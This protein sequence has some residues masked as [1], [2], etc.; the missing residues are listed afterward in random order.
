MFRLFLFHHTFDSLLHADPRI[1]CSP[2]TMH[3][4][5][6]LYVVLSRKQARNKKV[7]QMWILHLTSNYSDIRYVHARACV[8]HAW[9]C[10]VS[11]RICVPIPHSHTAHRYT[12]LNGR[13][14]FHNFTHS[15]L[16]AAA[17]PCDGDDQVGGRCPLLSWHKNTIIKPG[18]DKELGMMRLR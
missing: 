16:S 13:F 14:I 18:V 7:R 5:C 4:C 11:C 17:L 2:S 3:A 6:P 10:A 15:T 8:C 1:L 9:R 12:L